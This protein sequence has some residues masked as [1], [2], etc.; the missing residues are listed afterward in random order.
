M[1]LM[2]QIAVLR[3]GD[4]PLTTQEI[5][6]RDAIEAH[7]VRLNSSTAIKA[8][9]AEVVQ[10]EKM[11]QSRPIRTVAT[12]HIDYRNTFSALNRQ[13]EGLEL[14]TK[15]LREDSEAMR[16]ILRKELS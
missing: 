15:C 16:I 3:G 11:K 7:H 9:L 13:R 5:R 2:E 8:K 14:L 4:R 6:F 12:Q 1:H 10:L